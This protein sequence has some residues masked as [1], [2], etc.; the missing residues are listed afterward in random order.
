MLI[1][2]KITVPLNAA[3]PYERLKIH[4]GD[5]GHSVEV[6]I[7]LNGLKYTPPKGTE[8]TFHA[9]KAD[10]KMVMRTEGV[11]VVGST[12]LVELT[13]NALV[14]EGFVHCEVLLYAEGKTIGTMKWE[15]EVPKPAIA[16]RHVISLS[17]YQALKEAVADAQ[18]ARDRAVIERDKAEAAASVALEAQRKAEL[19]RDDAEESAAYS[20]AAQE[21]A[22]DARDEAEAYAEYSQKA[23]QETEIALAA[24][25]QAQKEAELARD[26]A[27]D[28]A[29]ADMCKEDYD[30][31][32]KVINTGGIAAF[33]QSHFYYL[34]EVLWTTPNYGH[35]P[36]IMHL[37][38][39]GNNQHGYLI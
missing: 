13:A 1:T 24:A 26:E 7:L 6:T 2:H 16:P 3:P 32:R 9:R 31:D 17:D 4:C 21:R 5:S 12:V 19:A 35:L 15:I 36:D 18:A 30:A 33:V 11:A 39:G 27:Y 25:L 10:G 28:A 23:L 20:Q 37:G 38:A 29:G 34:K 14:V 22:E 8:A